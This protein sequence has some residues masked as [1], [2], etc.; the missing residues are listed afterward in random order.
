MRTPLICTPGNPVH[1]RRLRFPV[2]A[3]EDAHLL[4]RLG[5]RVAV[6][7]IARHAAHPDHQ[8]LSVRGG[9]AHLHAELVR[10]AG[11]AF[12]D[13]LDF[14]SMQRIQLVLVFRALGEDAAVRLSKS[15]TFALACSG[16][17]A[18]WRATSC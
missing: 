9:N 3:R 12:L 16:S 4:E 8:T 15:M 17:C 14:G 2:S 11:P 18:T 5:Q 7:R 13:A 10:C 1:H 6:I